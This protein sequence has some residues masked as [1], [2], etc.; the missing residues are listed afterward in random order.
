MLKTKK[1]NMVAGLVLII[2]LISISFMGMFNLADHSAY[3]TEVNSENITWTFDSEHHVLTINGLGNG[4]VNSIN[5]NDLV[6][7]GLQSY[8][9][10]PYDV[11]IT[12]VTAIGAYA[13]S[14]FKGVKSITLPSTLLS[15]S[16]GAFLGI[17]CDVSMTHLDIPS[18]VTSIGQNAL[19]FNIA[20]IE[21]LNTSPSAGSINS[22][23]FY[24]TDNETGDLRHPT[25]I[26]VPSGT[27]DAY[28]TAMC[29][30]PMVWEDVVDEVVEGSSGW[31]PGF[32][33]K[34]GSS[35]SGNEQNNGSGNSNIEETGIFIDVI[36]PTIVIV[37]VLLTTIVV[38][39]KKEQN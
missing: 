7:G 8:E 34:S 10:A 3:A 39:R 33:E 23:A 12:G 13:L 36:M 24:S 18:S 6:T 27:I 17:E 20:E 11:V 4:T 30:S 14:G 32:E 21:F 31:V 15:I 35:G 19:G 38:W 25:K 16:A 37:M 2:L 28:K 9:G 22:S 5:S 29:T 1:F 26:I